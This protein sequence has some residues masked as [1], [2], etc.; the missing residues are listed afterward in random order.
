MQSFKA[1]D[2]TFERFV[3]FLEVLDVE[4]Q[5][6]GVADGLHTGVLV[7]TDE[8]VQSAAFHV[9]CDDAV[10]ECRGVLPPELYNLWQVAVVLDVADVCLQPLVRLVH[11]EL[12]GSKFLLC[13]V[14]CYAVEMRITESSVIEC[15]TG[16]EFISTSV[17]F[18]R[19]FKILPYLITFSDELEVS[20]I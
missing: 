2:A 15:Y 17:V 1:S 3:A 7:L 12:T 14:V 20:R 9:L 5:Q 13:V 11:H 16:Y 18:S 6:F 19:F 4:Q 10:L 8:R